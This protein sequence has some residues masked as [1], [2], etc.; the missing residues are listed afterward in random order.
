MKH[1]LKRADP[2]SLLQPLHIHDTATFDHSFRTA[3]LAASLAL[4]LGCDE[5]FTH[6][7]YEAA[8]L[9]DIGKIRTPVSILSAPRKLTAEEM[10]IMQRHPIYSWEIL[11][12]AGRFDLAPIARAHH[13]RLDGT[14]YPDK[15]SGK[16][17]PLEARIISVADVY[18]ALTTDRPYHTS[19]PTRDALAVLREGAELWWDPR[20]IEALHRIA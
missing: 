6:R 12:A 20:V 5:V 7:C 16:Q 10:Q 19:R 17:I 11:C 8:L 14:G 2:G 3:N 9:H 15:L 4:S 18:D 13:E 1:L